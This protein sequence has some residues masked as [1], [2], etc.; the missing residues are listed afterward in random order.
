MVYLS[1]TDG[2]LYQHAFENID[3]EF[4]Y[5]DLTLKQIGIPYLDVLQV[6]TE[7]GYAYIELTADINQYNNMF[8]FKSKI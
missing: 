5:P 7:K 8:Q 6:T 2:G 3:E 1:I 4:P